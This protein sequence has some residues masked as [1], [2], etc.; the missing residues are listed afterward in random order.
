[1][2]CTSPRRKN[3]WPVTWTSWRISASGNWVG[4]YSPFDQ[5]GRVLGAYGLA[6]Q[7]ATDA[8]ARPNNARFGH[9]YYNRTGTAKSNMFDNK[10]TEARYFYTD[11]DSDGKRLDGNGA[12]TVSCA[13]SGAAGQWFLVDNALQ[14]RA[15]L[16]RERPEAL[17]ARH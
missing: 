9:D 3:N 8:I 13:G 14:R 2:R 10:P 12:Y 7:Q 17:F 6:H 4:P 15:L 5:P 16:P 11:D 1:M